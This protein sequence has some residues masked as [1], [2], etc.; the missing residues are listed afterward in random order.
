MRRF[1]WILAF[2]IA[3]V[4]DSVF[5]YMNDDSLR[6]VSKPLLLVLVAGMVIACTQRV[7][8]R[9]KTLLLVALAASWAGD[10]LLLG[11]PSSY[12]MSGIGAFLIAQVAY[13]FCFLHLRRQKGIRFRPLMLVPV[14]T[15]YLCLITLLFEHLDVAFRIPVVIYGL[16]ISF[17]LAMA[18]QLVRMKNR[19]SAG[20]IFGGALLFIASDSVLALTKFYWKETSTT[21]ALFIMI[22]YA[23]AQLCLSLGLM[24][25]IS[26][27]RSHKKSAE[28][29]RQ[30]LLN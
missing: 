30:E 3:L 19:R 12:F 7:H 22:T 10:V 21:S 16:G 5:I 1:Y 14:G 8:T 18:I 2:T 9:L 28:A 25:H 29:I 4:C 17:M 6:V 15:Y 27:P 13:G 20:L 24:N 26:I 11:V 23:L